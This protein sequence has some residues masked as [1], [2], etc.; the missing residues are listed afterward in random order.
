VWK[1]NFSEKFSWQ[2]S[3][4][5]GGCERWY[6]DKGVLE[7]YDRTEEVSEPLRIED[8]LWRISTSNHSQ[9][10]HTLSLASMIKTYPFLER[11]CRS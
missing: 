10:T 11:R 8:D 9:L 7:C 2:G 5:K 4:G 1:R 3:L 6:H